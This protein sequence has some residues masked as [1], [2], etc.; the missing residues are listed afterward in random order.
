MSDSEENGIDLVAQGLS[1]LAHL[2]GQDEEEKAIAIAHMLLGDFDNMLTAMFAHHSNIPLEEASKLTEE[3]KGQ[4]RQVL[5]YAIDQED[6][7]ID[8]EKNQLACQKFLTP[9]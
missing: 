9:K 3:L 1:V 2:S 4:Y 5:Q 6:N 7:P 8:K